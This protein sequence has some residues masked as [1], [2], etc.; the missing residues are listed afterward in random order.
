MESNE[1]VLMRSRKIKF[2]GKVLAEYTHGTRNYMAIIRE[3]AGW[4]GD[5]LGELNQGEEDREQFDQVLKTIEKQIKIMEQT[6]E[7]LSRFGVRMGDGS[8]DFNPREIVEEAV[9]FFTR[10][11]RRHEGSI[12]SEVT[13]TLPGLHGDPLYIHVLVWMLINNILERVGSGG[14]IILRARMQGQDVLIEVEGHRTLEAAPP[15]SEEARQYWSV[16]EQ[17][18]NDL[19]GRLETSTIG[20]DTERTGLFLP[21][22]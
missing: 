17:I 4:L 15:V 19:G 20:S 8:S 21:L 10:F 22:N 1:E 7:H 6:T 13:E 16:G 5:L 18:A 12:K 9:S 11:V 14:Q 3:S 2:I